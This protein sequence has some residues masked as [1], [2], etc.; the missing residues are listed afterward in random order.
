MSQYYT[1]TFRN[2][3]DKLTAS[4]I[5]SSSLKDHAAEL[6]ENTKKLV[7]YIEG[8]TWKETGK[9]QVINNIIP[10]LTGKINVYI[11]NINNN[12]IPAAD[13]AQKELYPLLTE[14]NTK[15]DELESLEQEL[16]FDATNGIDNS[17][18]LP[19][20]NKTVDDMKDL[21]ARVK[22]VLEE[23]N[24]LNAMKNLDG[25]SIV[26]EITN[27]EVVK[28]NTQESTPVA[29][30]YTPTTATV[31]EVYVP[32][33]PIT[34]TSAGN[35]ENVKKRIRSRKKS[36][37]DRDIVEDFL[38]IK[39]RLDNQ[40]QVTGGLDPIPIE[41]K[42]D[43]TGNNNVTTW[44]TLGNNWVITNTQFSVSEYADYAYSKGIRQDSNSGR[45]GDLCLAFSYVHASNL[46]SGSKGDNAESAVNWAHAGEFKDYFSDNKQTTLA[47]VYDEILKGN[48]V[49]MQVNGNSEGTHRHFVTVV[50]FKDSVT[51]AETI[52]ESD[53]LILD[54][55]DGKLETMD[56]D[57]SRFMTTG[58]QT[59]KTYSGYY[60]R[61]FR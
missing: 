49:I 2:Y 38:R 5:S 36:L 6:E 48:P 51:S 8:T 17:S 33:V 53:L 31:E 30:G 9:D 44:N 12:L 15:E 52:K 47:T 10:K 28:E 34:D 58:A 46:K 29:D 25:S 21:S 11:S 4:P 43:I 56:T 13:K 50:G 16:E 41:G 59:G 26:G 27:K 61:L 19:I 23:I 32:N 40:K 1:D 35:I 55:W 20:Y 14:L 3:Y 39:R 18:I 24:D 7:S 54:S 42:L 57:Y 60:L 22:I 37:F 45:Y